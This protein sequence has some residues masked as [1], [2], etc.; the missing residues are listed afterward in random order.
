MGLRFEA[1]RCLLNPGRFRALAVLPTV[2]CSTKTLE[3]LE[4]CLENAQTV[5]ESGS[6]LD[7]EGQ[8]R[9]IEYSARDKERR[10]ALLREMVEAVRTHCEVIPAYGPDTLPDG[11]EKAEEALEA[12]EYSAMLLIAERDAT[13]LT[14]DGRLAQ[15][16]AATLQRPWV[17][18]QVL[19]MHAGSKGVIGPRDYS[20]AVLQQ[21]LSNRT[22]VSLAADD[23]LWM[24]LQGGFTLRYGIQQFKEY[25]ASPDTEFVSGARV[26]LGFLNLVASHHSQVKAFAELLGHLV[27]GALRHPSAD[28]EWLLAKITDLA[29]QVVVST[30]GPEMHYPPLE[31]LREARANALG[32]FLGEAVQAGLELTAQPDQRRAVKLDALKCTVVPHLVFDGDVP[33]LEAAVIAQVEPTL[34]PEASGQ[35]T[36]LSE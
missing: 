28:A 31:T 29:A 25:L 15:L 6:L 26:A 34:P 13:L 7:D 2:Y 11:L 16:A 19:L 20:Q 18:P 36:S 4:V 35:K 27:E 30:A 17:W 33:E 21:F 9:F 32:T 8:I 12:E 22:F 24:A 5:G 14:V 3:V 10:V 1:R 23:L